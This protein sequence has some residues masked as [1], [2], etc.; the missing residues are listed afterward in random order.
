[1]WFILTGKFFPE[2][3][4]RIR[5]MTIRRPYLLSRTTITL[6]VECWLPPEEVLE[7]YRH[8]QHQI[9][10]GTPHSLKIN[11]K[12]RS[13]GVNSVTPGTRRTLASASGTEATCA[14][15]TGERL[16]P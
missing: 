9:L 4:V 10:G 7:Q 3:Q 12:K 2:D 5:Y 6:E 16:I 8:A 13:V 11:T 15:H 1:M 14:P